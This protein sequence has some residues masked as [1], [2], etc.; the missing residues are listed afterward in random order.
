M[1]LPVREDLSASSSSSS[2]AGSSGVPGLGICKSCLKRLLL[3]GMGERFKAFDE[4]GIAKRGVQQD[5]GK[6]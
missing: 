3:M 1:N 5:F 4:S 2:P 6:R